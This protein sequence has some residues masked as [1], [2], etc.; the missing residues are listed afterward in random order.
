MEKNNGSQ[1]KSFGYIY[2]ISEF[3]FVIKKKKIKKKKK[4]KK[5]KSSF[6]C[7]GLMYMYAIA[8]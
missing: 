1:Q 6:A 4:K 2:L 5:K 8:L 7:C 3:V